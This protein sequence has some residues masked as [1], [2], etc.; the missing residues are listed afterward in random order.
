MHLYF[1]GT[2]ILRFF[3]SVFYV[4][5]RNTKNVKKNVKVKANVKNVK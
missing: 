2:G 3:P 1:T 4:K 5:K